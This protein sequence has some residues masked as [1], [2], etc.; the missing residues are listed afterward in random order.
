M[1]IVC[2]AT[3]LMP[4]TRAALDLSGYEWTER[5]V[6]ASDE[7]YWELLNELW[8]SGEDFVIV[9]QDIVIDQFALPAFAE[10]GAEWCANGYPYLR[11]AN[12]AGLGCTRFK[13]SLTERF[14]DL[15]DRVAEFD[16]PGHG[17]KHWCTLDAAMQN[18]LHMAQQWPHLHGIVGHLH[19]W[20]THG[21]VPKPEGVA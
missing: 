10:C 2:P 3:N 21:C 17:P 6:S 15:M 4:Q 11:G 14:P 5:D 12:Y 1:N 18:Q 7:S 13:A 19:S 8:H 20:P 9:E 16:Y